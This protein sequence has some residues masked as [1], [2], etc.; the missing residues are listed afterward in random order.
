LENIVKLGLNPA[1][2]LAQI[3]NFTLLLFI[4][5]AVAYKPVLKMLSDRKQKIQ[6]SL[7]YAERVK[8]EAA[9]QQKE[10]DRKLEEAR[11]QAQSAATA[12]A[13]VGEKEREVIV[14]QAREE[15]RKLI[16]QAKGQIEYERKQMMSD[17]REEVV[18][19]SLLAAQH[20]VS[21]SLDD[22]AHRKLVSEFLAQSDKLGKQN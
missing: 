8:R 20:V 14:A 1:W 12:A 15:A 22:Q 9:D 11:R 6:E 13:Q 5:R 2:L 17:L 18:R 19:L 3:I 10:F 16:E 7:E 4:L 21:Q